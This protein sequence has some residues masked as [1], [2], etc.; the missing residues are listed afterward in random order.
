MTPSHRAAPSHPS[1]SNAQPAVHRPPSDVEQS[2]SRLSQI[3]ARFE[4]EGA[5]HTPCAP[6]SAR[7]LV[8]VASPRTFVPRT[9]DSSR[10]PQ[11]YVVRPPDTAQR[12]ARQMGH[13]AV[14]LPYGQPWYKP[15][16]D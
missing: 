10:K 7:R 11:T 6:S 4:G 13:Q 16:L 1:A 8:Y 14:K 12:P 5:L 9:P 15:L 3:A 2:V